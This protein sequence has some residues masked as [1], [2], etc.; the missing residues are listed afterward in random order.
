[1][2]LIHVPLKLAHVEHTWRE[3]PDKW[4]NLDGSHW[5]S[6]LDQAPSSVEGGLTAAVARGPLREE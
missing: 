3:L 6:L 2:L 5:D 1:M 4:R